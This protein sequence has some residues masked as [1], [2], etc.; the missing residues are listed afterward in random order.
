MVHTLVEYAKQATDNK[1]RAVIELFP[2]E[3]D[4]LR[5]IPFKSAPGGRYGY[6]REGALPTNIA[7]RGINETPT[8]GFGL[9]N[10]FT[11]QCF[12][13]AGQIKIDRVLLD[14]YGMERRSMEERL[15]IKAKAHAWT[16]N[17][18]DGDNQSEP[19][20]WTGLKQR[21]RAVGSGATSV[22]GSNYESRVLANSTASGGGAL[23]LT[24]LDIAISLVENPTHILMPYKLK[25]RLPAAVRAAGVGGVYTND[26]EDMGRRV[27]RYNG[28]ELLTGYGI[29]KHGALLNFNEVAYGGGSAV[30]SSIYV[31]SFGEMG[32]CGI[33]TKPMEVKD[34]GLLE[35]G[36]HY[37]TD[38]HHDN[39]ICIETP[40]AA[41]RMTSI[42]DAAIIA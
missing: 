22:D 11:E 38:V 13:M 26:T 36:V 12:P 8:D 30:T 4:I 9:I 27:E 42:A 37:L 25:H 39:G 23:S 24:M 18:L 28:L 5:V 14:R 41:L 7:F 40:Y 3:S 17:F 21:L 6:F 32:V 2:E 35:N 16:Q 34:M 33:E 19:R 20:E 15:Q 29:S 10:D 1:T 31:L